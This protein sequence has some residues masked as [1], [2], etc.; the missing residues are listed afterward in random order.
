MAALRMA[1]Q[2][3]LETLWVTWEDTGEH[4]GSLS[5]DQ[6][7]WYAALLAYR[8][9]QLD[10]CLAVCERWERYVTKERYGAPGFAVFR[11]ACYLNQGQ[12]EMATEAI[13]VAVK[14]P[15]PNYGYHLD[16]QIA[17]LRKAIDAR[18]TEFRYTPCRHIVVEGRDVEEKDRPDDWEFL[19]N[20]E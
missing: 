13:K 6:S 5:V 14:P 4:F 7:A 3:P 17:R 12:F 15:P 20:Y 11:A 8:E 1:T 16:K 18:D 9:Q 2:S 19:V 10:V